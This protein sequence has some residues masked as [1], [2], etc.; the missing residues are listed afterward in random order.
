MKSFNKLV[1]IL[2]DSRQPGSIETYVLQ[3][4]EGLSQHNINVCVVFLNNYGFHP[5]RRALHQQHIENLSLDGTIASLCHELR[6][7]SSLFIHTHGYKAGILGRF[8][9]RLL[10]NP[11]VSTYHSGEICSE[12]FSI[13]NSAI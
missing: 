6:M 10:L 2:L 8:C 3:L 5:L 1:W 7:Q 4:A 12:K 9:T 11:F 13:S